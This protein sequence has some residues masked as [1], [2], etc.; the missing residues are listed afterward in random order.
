MPGTWST[1][2]I[3]KQPGVED[4]RPITGYGGGD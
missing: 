2:E 3:A 4:R 1:D